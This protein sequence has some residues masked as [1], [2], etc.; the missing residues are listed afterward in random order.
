MEIQAKVAMA[1]LALVVSSP[2]AN[3]QH[4]ASGPAPEPPSAGMNRQI[5]HPPMPPQHEQWNRGV[6][7]RSDGNWRGMRLQGGEHRQFLLA[8]LVSNPIFRDRVGIT[9]AQ[10]LKIRTQTLNFRKDQIRNRAKLQVGR[11][12]LKDLLSTDNPDRNA[13]D[14]KL[15]EI[16]AVRLAQAKL[17]I[18]F[19]LDMRAALTPD[20]QQKLRQ[21]REDFFRHR[22]FGGRGPNDARGDTHPPSPA[23]Y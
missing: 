19:H 23:G 4:S 5:M 17:A 12:E 8:R 21:M 15:Q 16:S 3:G 7:W 10:A 18:G 14:Q 6:A 11:L 2:L 20:Q 22:G 9:P 1:L 13:I